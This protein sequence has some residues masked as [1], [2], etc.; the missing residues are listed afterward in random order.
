MASSIL[1]GHRLHEKLDY[2]LAEVDFTLLEK[3]VEPFEVLKYTRENTA[4]LRPD[5]ITF[6]G[7]EKDHPLCIYSGAATAAG[8]GF[9]LK[10]LK[11]LLPN[12]N[13]LPNE[14]TDKW[15]YRNEDE[16]EFCLNE[17]TALVKNRLLKWFEAPVMNPAGTD[18]SIKNQLSEQELETSLREQVKI[19]ELALIRAEAEDR[20]QDVERYKRTLK[21]F[22]D[23]LSNLKRGNT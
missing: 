20:L 2:I 22:Q 5:V 12:F 7:L 1:F 21:E 4:H 19:F 6:H 8:D 16:L 9:F 15:V 23:K 11:E 14:L 3:Q 13:S 17:I 10:S 18:M